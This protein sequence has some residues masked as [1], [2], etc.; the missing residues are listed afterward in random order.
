MSS[1]VSLHR[2]TWPRRKTLGVL[3]PPRGSL[4][5]VV[6][7][8]A[9][10]S[11]FYYYN[12]WRKFGVPTRLTEFVS[13]AGDDDGDEPVLDNPRLS[14]NGQWIACGVNFFDESPFGSGIITVPADGGASTVLTDFA[15][16]DDWAL[17]PSWHPDNDHVLFIHGPGDPPSSY[18]FA[19]SIKRAQR[20]DP[21]V[22]PTELWSPEIQTPTQREAA[23]RPHY[24][25]D[26]SLIAFLV[27]IEAGGGGD[28]ARQ[29]LWVMDADGTNDS[30]IRSFASGSTTE[31]GYLYSGTQL[32]WSNDGEW[33][34]FLADG[35]GGGESSIYKIR[36]DG[37]DE[38]LLAEGVAAGAGRH[39]RLGHAAW[40]P[41]DSFL[42][43]SFTDAT[44]A[45]WRVMRVEADGSNTDGT[46][47]V[48][49]TNGPAGG[50][51]FE[52][53][54]RNWLTNRIEWISKAYSTFPG[55]VMSCAIDGSDLAIVHELDDYGT[56]DLFYSGT[57]HEWL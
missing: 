15:G 20:T 37:T 10:N 48:D 32:A 56:G 38:T 25:P 22:T 26:G 11:P 39:W 40:A 30:L 57:G 51:Y 49:E 34:A 23:Y 3:A 7:E 52:C 18:G 19:G 27:T 54:Y 29:G 47:L 45:D 44:S 9:F 5:Y 46:E 4:P 36:P 31:R 28:T 13:T 2:L 8:D 43:A 14:P 41:D 55:T 12:L 24:S 53:V 17:H 33:I 35:W 21:G 16:D 50:Q 1:I 42:V 6:L